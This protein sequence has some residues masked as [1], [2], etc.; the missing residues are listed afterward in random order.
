MQAIIHGAQGST[1]QKHTQI[2]LQGRTE[3]RMVWWTEPWSPET[4][5]S[6]S[7]RACIHVTRWQKACRCD[8][9]KDFET[10]GYCGLSGQSNVITGPV[11]R[12]AGGPEVERGLNVMTRCR[13][14]RWNQVSRAEG[15]TC[16][17]CIRGLQGN[18]SSLKGK[19]GD[20]FPGSPGG[21]SPDDP[22][23][24]CETRSGH[25]TPRTLR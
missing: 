5:T 12:E 24:A 7:L 23:W 2:R 15:C 16:R 13:L 11:K 14:W 25:L 9:G 8:E 6:S 18:R 20:E 4:P 19:E 1:E 17:W 22:W 3:P 21:A 10:G